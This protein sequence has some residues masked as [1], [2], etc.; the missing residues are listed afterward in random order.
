MQC[1]SASNQAR[2]LPT[3][4]ARV[5]V[6]AMQAAA[7][8]MGPTPRALPLWEEF[9]LRFFAR[10][11]QLEEPTAPSDMSDRLAEIS[12]ACSPEFPELASLLA[13][14]AALDPAALPGNPLAEPPPTR[15]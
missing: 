15:P 13:M 3:V 2:T 9:A 7:M 10:W 8:R 14:L 4:R 12:G 1:W 11:E 6:R 5:R